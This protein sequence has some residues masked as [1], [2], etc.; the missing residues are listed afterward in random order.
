MVAQLLQMLVPLGA[1]QVPEELSSLGG[2]GLCTRPPL[3]SLDISPVDGRAGQ[4]SS[5]ILPLSAGAH[6]WCSMFLCGLNGSGGEGQ[7]FR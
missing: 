6:T 7:E 3:G 2:D 1:I 5:H 4:C